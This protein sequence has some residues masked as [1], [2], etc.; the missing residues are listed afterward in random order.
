VAG[1]SFGEGQIG[2]FY[3]SAPDWQLAEIALDPALA[4]HTKRLIFSWRND[5]GGGSQPPAAIDNL[6]I[7]SSWPWL[8]TASV[9]QNLQIIASGSD[10]ILTW[11]KIT[12]ANDYII[13]DADMFD[14][15]F[16]PLG[17]GDNSFSTAGSH[18]RR[19]F[20]IRATE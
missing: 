1:S 16:S 3:H 13:E 9:P 8:D 18:P 6:R 17:R 10:V 20:R 15:S 12:G 5:G 19:F 11:D 7:Y 4:G 2:G 14:G